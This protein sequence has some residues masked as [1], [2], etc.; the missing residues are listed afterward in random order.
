CIK[1]WS[2]NQ[3]PRLP[4]LCPLCRQAY[5]LLI[6]DCR[7]YAYRRERMRPPAH[8]AALSSTG[9]DLHLT[10]QHRRRRAS[11]FSGDVME[12]QQQGGEDGM[13]PPWARRVS[14][15]L[16]ARSDVARW[17]TRELQAILLQG[18]VDLLGQHLLGTLRGAAQLGGG[19]RPG[20]SGGGP[21]HAVRWSPFWS[22]VLE[23]CCAPWRWENGRVALVQCSLAATLKPHSPLCKLQDLCTRLGT[24]AGPFLHRHATRFAQQLVSFASSGQSL[25]TWDAAAAMAEEVLV[26]GALAA[27]DGNAATTADG[28]ATFTVVL[29]GLEDEDG[30]Q[31]ISGGDG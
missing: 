22:R 13:T 17:V 16:A 1:Q 25:A 28:D 7:D 20:T 5:T 10:V 23:V 18:D 9:S 12:V 21:S 6:T 2:Q 29:S 8:E 19:A 15:A 24:A 3:D 26:A 27:S 30:R 31:P 14:P 4:L 11:Y